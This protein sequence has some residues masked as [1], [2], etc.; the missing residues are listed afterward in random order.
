MR[1]NCTIRTERTRHHDGPMLDSLAAILDE[2]R[3]QVA[4]GRAP[5]LE[6]LEARIAQLATADSAAVERAREALRSIASV[7]RARAAVTREPRAV[8]A[9]RAP[10]ALR[11]RATITGTLDVRRAD[12]D[13]FRLVWDAVPAVSEWE[14]RFSE[15]PDVRSDYVGRETL[16]L[17]AGETSVELPLSHKPFRVTVLGRGRGRLQRRALVSGLTRENWRD[18]WQRR[19]TAS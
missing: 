5:N 6:G 18:R 13:G 9:Q 14:V 16:V 8:P 19:A 10:A 2:A 4:A 12:G 11:A 7:H 1:P 17:A 15:R 3:A